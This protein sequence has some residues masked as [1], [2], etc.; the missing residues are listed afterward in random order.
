MWLPGPCGELWPNN[1]TNWLTGLSYS[2]SL[3]REMTDRETMINTRFSKSPTL[4]QLYFLHIHA[5]QHAHALVCVHGEGRVDLKCSSSGAAHLV[6]WGFSLWLGDSGRL[7]VQEAPRICL[8]PPSGT[9]TTNAC[10]P[11]WVLGPELRSSCLHP[12]VSDTTIFTAP[13]H[14][15]F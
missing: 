6:C 9:G 14:G 2:V 1:V 4:F 11:A 13:T 15:T 10:Y 3:G 12:H 5:C 7:V 8:P